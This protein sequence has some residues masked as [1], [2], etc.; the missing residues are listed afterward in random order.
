MLVKVTAP[1]EPDTDNPVPATAEVTPVLE[2]VT[3]PVAPET[4]IPE[5]ATLDVTPV[6]ANVMEPL[7]VIGLPET[8]N[9]VPPVT[10]T[11]VT[12]PAVPAR[13]IVSPVH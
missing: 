11:L 12:A 7:L 1:V 6:F 5:P 10:P 8:D 4:E 13:V 3:A 9:P 2:I